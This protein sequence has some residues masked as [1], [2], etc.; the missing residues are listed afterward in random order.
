MR[1]AWILHDKGIE[2]RVLS[3]HTVKPIDVKAITAAFEDTKAVVTAE[4]HQVGGFG[5]LVARVA[6][7]ACLKKPIKMQMIGVRDEFGESG[8]PWELIWKF[9]LAG[10]HI[11]KSA[12]ELL[13]K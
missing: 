9:G 6:G 2:A 11:A 13:K 7:E 8:Q 3:I 12:M 10:E 4:E 5:N 1:A